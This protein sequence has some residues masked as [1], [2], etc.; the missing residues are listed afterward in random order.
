MYSKYTKHKEKGIRTHHYIK[1]SS[2]KQPQKDREKR[3]IKETQIN[4]QNGNKSLPTNNDFSL[5]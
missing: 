2:N 3:T 5:K 4:E 1:Y